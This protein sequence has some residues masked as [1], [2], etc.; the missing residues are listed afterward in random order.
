MVTKVVKW[1]E[2]ENH[3][4]EEI[5]KLKAWSL[6]C[7]TYVELSKVITASGMEMKIVSIF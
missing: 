6:A 2:V 1:S 4:N 5:E 7:G 3:G